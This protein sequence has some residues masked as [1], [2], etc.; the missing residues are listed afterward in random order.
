[1]IKMIK[2]DDFNPNIIELFLNSNYLERKEL[3]RYINLFA[4]KIDGKVLDFGCGSKPYEKLFIN[5]DKYIGLEIKDGGVNNADI[6]YDGKKLP[7]K[8]KEFN[9]MVSFQVLYQVI[10]L[11]E[12]LKEINRV[13]KKDAKILVSVPFIWF[14]GGANIQRRFSQEYSKFIFKK[15]GFEVLEIKQTNNNFSALCLLISKYIDYSI[16]KIKYI[17]L[18]RLLRIIQILIINSLF[19]ILGELFLKFGSKDNELYIDNIIYAKKIK[20]V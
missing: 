17:Y 12:I 14:D 2:T 7:F 9:A 10:N 19:N 6:F 20:S 13:L 4:S 15:F 16:S 18:R 8:D 11:E 5:S 1:M 3:Y